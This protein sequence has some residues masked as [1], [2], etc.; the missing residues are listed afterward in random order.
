MLF[1]I[2]YYQI[3]DLKSEKE[4]LENEIQKLRLKLNELRICSSTNR[5][6]D[7]T[8]QLWQHASEIDLFNAKMFNKNQKKEINSKNVSKYLFIKAVNSINSP[9]LLLGKGLFSFFI[10]FKLF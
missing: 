3:N 8:D 2:I 10:N 5:I 1:F 9:Y 7:S 4:N 6:L